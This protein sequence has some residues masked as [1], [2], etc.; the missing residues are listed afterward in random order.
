MIRALAFVLESRP[1]G[2]LQRLQSVAVSVQ[3]RF[4]GEADINRQAKPAESVENDPS[5]TLA[6]I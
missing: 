3:G 1:E 2:W 6:S 4:R 5:A